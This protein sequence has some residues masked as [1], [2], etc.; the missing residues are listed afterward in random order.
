MQLPKGSPQPDGPPCTEMVKEMGYRLR[1]KTTCGQRKKERG[2]TQPRPRLFDHP[3]K[4]VSR[5]SFVQYS[6]ESWRVFKFGEVGGWWAWQGK[7]QGRQNKSE[8]NRIKKRWGSPEGEVDGKSTI[9]SLL[10]VPTFFSNFPLPMTASILQVPTAY[11]LASLMQDHTAYNLSS[12]L[13][14]STA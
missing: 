14:V 4:S 1:A 12:L 11:D 7:L 9:L 10:K 8:V 2:I 6:A 3:C 5:I 13:Q